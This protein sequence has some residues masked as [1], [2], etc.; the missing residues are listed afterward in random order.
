MNVRARAMVPSLKIL[1]VTLQF[2]CNQEA[3]MLPTLLKCFPHL[4]KL[5]V[6]V[7]A[8]AKLRR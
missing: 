8:D 4:E 5:H 3:K 1:A 6:L 7:M 2:A